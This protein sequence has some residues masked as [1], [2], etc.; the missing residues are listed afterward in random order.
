MLFHRP[1]T[2]PRRHLL[3]LLAGLLLAP[4]ASP[5]AGAPSPAQPGRPT[6]LR[7]DVVIVTVDT[8]R[9]DRLSLY[10]YTRPTTPHLDRLLAAGVHFTQARVA[11][12]LTAPSMVSMITSLHP[13]EHGSSRNGLRMRPGLPSLSKVLERRGYRTA[14]L[15]GNWTLR[16]QISGLG[17]HF[18]DYREVLTRK[19]WLVLLGEAT[20]TDLTDEALEWI[21]DHRDRPFLLWVH[22]VEPHEPYR[23]HS[24]FA[25]RLGID[26]RHQDVSPADR[27]DTE[28]AFVDH[29]I[30][31]LLAGLEALP[32]PP[33]VLF[34][35]DHGESLGEHNYWGHG[36]HLYDVTLRVPLSLTWKG[37]LE[38][39]RIDAPA[40][41]LDLA[42]TLF[43]VVGWPLPPTFRGYDW[44]PV[45]RGEEPPPNDRTTWHQAHKGAVQRSGNRKARRQGLLEVGRVTAGHKEIL[46]VTNDHR[47]IFD[48]LGDPR[49]TR[50][51]ATDGDRPSA[52]LTEWLGRVREGLAAA[53]ELPAATL[54]EE[55]VE[56]LKA[57]GYID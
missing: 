2:S 3:A 43:G 42:P 13:H 52:E 45:L 24:Q 57:L 35:S 6:V 28:V 49:E 36:R 10:G 56:Q 38:P 18:E 16:D 20:A 54:D 21:D 23:F 47:R 14:A 39:R 22:Y 17:E 27:Y 26:G 7:P 33:L 25:D 41:V 37:H 40:S 15:V 55:S 32:R 44:S 4:L 31:R 8:L 53:D 50:S 34:A 51:L 1:M 5:A 29:E 30:G 9:F 12:P 11:E 19:R 48:V 46:R